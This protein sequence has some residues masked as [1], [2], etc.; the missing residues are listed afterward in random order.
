[1]AS[2]PIRINEATIDK[3]QTLLGIGPQRVA[4]IASFRQKV[5]PIKT[6]V[7]LAAAAA[8][9]VNTATDIAAQIDWHPGTENNR[10]C[11]WPLAF[12]T[13]ASLWLL[14]LGSRQRTNRKYFQ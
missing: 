1:M 4:S 8:I 6:I 14:S 11:F 10:R 7:D 9:N 13:L 2:S 5:G 12:I 3:L